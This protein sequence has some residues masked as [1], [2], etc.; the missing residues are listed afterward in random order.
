VNTGRY[1]AYVMPYSKQAMDFNQQVVT[2]MI[3]IGGGSARNIIV[4]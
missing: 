1:I 3:P 4:E 2:Q